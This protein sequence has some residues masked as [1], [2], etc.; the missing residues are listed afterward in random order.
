M[1]A[2]AKSTFPERMNVLI[3]SAGGPSALAQ[4]SKLSRRVID[5]YRTGESEPSRE[6]LIALG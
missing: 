4:K 6:R 1:N 3:E 2:D 5:K